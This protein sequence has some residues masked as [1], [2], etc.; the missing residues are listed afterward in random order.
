MYLGSVDL[1]FSWLLLW[2]ILHLFGRV[3]VFVDLFEAHVCVDQVVRVRLT[4]ER[5]VR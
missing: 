1:R 3:F 4:L 2:L 5:D